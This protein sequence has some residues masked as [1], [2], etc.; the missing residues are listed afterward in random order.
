VP[1][2]L[3]SKMQRRSCCWVTETEAFSNSQ[4][5]PSGYGVAVG[6]FNRDGKPDLVVGAFEVLKNRSH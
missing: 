4:L 6:D 5:A 2:P 3:F 1:L